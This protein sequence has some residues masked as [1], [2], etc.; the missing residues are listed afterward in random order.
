MSSCIQESLDAARQPCA[1][2][3]RLKNATRMLGGSFFFSSAMNYFLATWIVT[4]PSGTA[5]FNEELG[6][7]TLYELSHD[8]ACRRC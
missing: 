8:R 7:L 1:F 4:S 3:T 2:E 6:R 5:A